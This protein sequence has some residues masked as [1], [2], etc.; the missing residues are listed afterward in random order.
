MPRTSAFAALPL[1]VLAPGTA[2]AQSGYASAPFREAPVAVAQAAALERIEATARALAVTPPSVEDAD[3]R[4]EIEEGEGG[5]M[6]DFALFRAS[7]AA[8][9]PELARSLDGA[10][11]TLLET[12]EAGED[13]SGAAGAVVALSQE[14]RDA[15]FGGANGDPVFRAALAASLLLDEG[16]VA[17]AYGEA[18]EGEASAYAV[19]WF[20][21]QRVKALWLGLAG[22]ATPEQTADVE[23]MLGMLDGLLPRRAAPERL[24][25]DPEQAE[26][27]AQQLVGLLEAITDAELYP[28]RDLA[29]ATSLVHDLA[30]RGCSSIEAGDDGLGVEE[31]TIAAAYYAQT[32]QATLVVMAPDA[33]AAIVDHLEAVKREQA[34]QAAKACGALLEALATGQAALTP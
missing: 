20:T 33:G 8:W 22:E 25:P 7:L 10:I 30:T 4:E 21:L 5:P 11:G 19:G 9:S 24:S 16:G 13:A 27:P 28:G 14:A 6:A 15:L 3:E 2:S 1:L 23:A 31:L 18:S 17:E 29:N 34:G 26:A 12:A 32:V